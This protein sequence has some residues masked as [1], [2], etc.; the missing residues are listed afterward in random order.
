MR[1]ILC[2]TFLGFMLTAA[3]S[4]FNVGRAG[5]AAGLTMIADVND[6][7]NDSVSLS[8][9]DLVKVC[10]SP[11]SG[12]RLQCASYVNASV[13]MI[14]QYNKRVETQLRICFPD[15]DRGIFRKVFMAWTQRHPDRGAEPAAKSLI[16]AFTE[17]FKCADKI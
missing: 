11:I 13:A 16:S 5:P 12:S 7:A 9:R 10:R 2:L 14:R 15:G 4:T 6:G 8:T 17:A 1:W 3:V